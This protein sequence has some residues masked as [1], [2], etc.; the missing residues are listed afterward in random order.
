MKPSLFTKLFLV[1]PIH[2]YDIHFFL[3]VYDLPCICLHI[4]SDA[5]T[6]LS[7]FFFHNSISVHIWRFQ[8]NLNLIILQMI[9]SL[10]WYFSSDFHLSE[11]YSQ[12]TTCLIWKPRF[13]VD[14]FQIHIFNS[15]NE[16]YWLCVLDIPWDYS[17]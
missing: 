5:Q 1:C 15:F 8:G 14:F 13:F 6:W 7:H 12:P 10:M 4:S 2:S 9:S 3:D 17:L 16:P 11:C